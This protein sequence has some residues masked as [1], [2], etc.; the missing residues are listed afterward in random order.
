MTYG[1]HF[2]Q[3]TREIFKSYGTSSA[4]AIERNFAGL[5]H[6]AL[7]RAFTILTLLQ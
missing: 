2:E 7:Q 1:W 5:E 4:D 6:A 3:V